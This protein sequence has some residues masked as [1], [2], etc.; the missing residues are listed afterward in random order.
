M[1]RGGSLV[2]SHGKAMEPGSQLADQPGEA[3]VQLLTAAATGD[4]PLAKRARAAGA[5]LDATEPQKSRC[6]M[7]QAAAHGCCLLIEY[8]LA[9][10][11]PVDQRTL[12]GHTPLHAAAVAGQSVTAELLIA[13][14]ATPAHW[15]ALVLLHFTGLRNKDTLLSSSCSCRTAHPQV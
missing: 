4:L 5:C 8:L 1:K 3:D 13:E 9:E 11:A 14:G 6:A 15:I 12:K 7:H 2:G 10:G